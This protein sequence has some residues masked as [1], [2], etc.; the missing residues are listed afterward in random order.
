MSDYF[1]DKHAVKNADWKEVLKSGAT[2]LENGVME[3]EDFYSLSDIVDQK[4]R[5]RT[6]VLD[7]RRDLAEDILRKKE[8][9]KKKEE[10]DN[11]KSNTKDVHSQSQ[12]IQPETTGESSKRKLELYDS[13]SDDINKKQKTNESCI[14]YVLEK[15]SCDMPDIPDSDGGGD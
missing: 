14:D 15:Q 2:L 8:A 5:A 9:E 1:S 6:D 10:E 11:L 3:H 7:R 4:D 12:D 13:D